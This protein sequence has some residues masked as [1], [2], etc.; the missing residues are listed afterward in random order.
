MVPVHDYYV[1]SVIIYHVVIIHVWLY[2]NHVFMLMLD[3]FLTVLHLYS[4]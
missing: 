1:D 4:G 2:F 3:N